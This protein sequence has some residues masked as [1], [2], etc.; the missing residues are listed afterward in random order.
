[1]PYP[2]HHKK[3][4]TEV[5]AY[6]WDASPPVMRDGAWQNAYRYVC[7]AFPDKA[8]RDAFCQTLVRPLQVTYLTADQVIY[9]VSD[10][11][12]GP[13]LYR[14]RRCVVPCMFHPENGL[15]PRRK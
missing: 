9:H 5:Y 10:P 8:K 6:L 12:D 15:L 1:M 4:P 11:V 3:T 2:E 13:E 14:D 7:L